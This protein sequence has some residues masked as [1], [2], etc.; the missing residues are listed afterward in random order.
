MSNVWPMTPADKYGGSFLNGA[1]TGSVL[2]SSSGPSHS[3][4]RHTLS[5][6]DP[7]F[8]ALVMG[9]LAVGLMY[10]STTVRVGPVKASLSAGTS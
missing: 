2:P 1:G 4:S 6:S 8:W 9:A 10:A 7:L 5:P 3:D